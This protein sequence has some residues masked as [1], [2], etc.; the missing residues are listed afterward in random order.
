MSGIIKMGFSILD[1][2]AATEVGADIL[3]YIKDLSS[4]E[5]K[6]LI[7]AAAILIL[8]LVWRWF[9]F[10]MVMVTLLV[11]FLAY[12]LFIN[13]IFYSYKEYQNQNDRHL[14]SIE[15]ELESGK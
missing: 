14:Q 10:A 2:V 11:Y 12:I 15:K 3:A 9:G 6:I 1:R 5:V 8:W 13:N 7:I 4:G